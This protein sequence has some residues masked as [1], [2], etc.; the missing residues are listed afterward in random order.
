MS[1]CELRSLLIL[2]LVSEFAGTDLQAGSTTQP[3]VR[4]DYLTFTWRAE[5]LAPLSQ[6]AWY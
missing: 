4:D 6:V 1:F 3:L 5:I 2:V